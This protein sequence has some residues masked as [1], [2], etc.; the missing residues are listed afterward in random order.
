M[1][2]RLQIDMPT[3]HVVQCMC[4]YIITFMCVCI[5]TF[6]CMYTC[7]T[8]LMWHMHAQQLYNESHK[9]PGNV[10]YAMVCR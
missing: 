8:A 4:M 1:E 10:F 3:R 5:I 9:H 2:T 6:F 7:M